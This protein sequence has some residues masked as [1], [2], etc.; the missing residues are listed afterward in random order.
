MATSTS[1]ASITLAA[2]AT[3]YALSVSGDQAVYGNALSNSLS[4]N[5]FDNF[6]SGN[7]GNDTLLGGLGNDTLLGGDGADRLDGGIG[8][9]SMAGGDGN[10][11]YYVDDVNDI[12][13]ELAGQGMDTVW[14][15]VSYT[16][17]A[18]VEALGLTGTANLTGTGNELANSISGNAGDNLIDGGAGN[19]TLLGGAGNDTLLGGEGNDLLNGGVGADV[20]MGGE[21]SD[22]L[23]GGL[24]ADTMQGGAGNDV[25]VVDNIGDVVIEDVNGGTDTVWAS[26]DYT[27]GDNVESLGLT[28]TANLT[29]IGNALANSISGNTG[30][31]LLDGGAGNDI[32]LGGAGDD[33]L[34]GGDG[35]DRLD[36]GLGAD[37]LVG[38]AGNDLY[39]IDDLGDV[40]VEDANGG[41]DSVSAS[42]D[43]TLGDTL[44]ALTLTGTADLTGTG[45][46]L[47]N[48]I[49]GNSGNN[50]LDGGA[51]ND[52]LVGGLGQ[53]TLIGGLG[54]DTFVVDNI[55][56]VVVEEAGQGIDTVQSSI[57]YTL[58]DTLENLSLIG[59][60]NLTGTGNA[61][62]NTL[63]GNAGNNVLDGGAGNDVLIGG[64][65][66][67]TLIG[68]AGN[69]GYQVDDIGDVVV[70]N[71][72]EGVDAVTIIATL[73]YTLGDNVENARVNSSGSMLTGNAMANQ[74]VSL[75]VSS[76]IYGMDGNDTISGGASS[77]LYGDNGDDSLT[78]TGTGS[79]AYGG[80]GNDTLDAR[81]TTGNWLVGG[82]GDDVYVVD[83]T[84]QY[85]LE[86]ANEGVDTVKSSVTFSLVAGAR[87][88]G[89]SVSDSLEN[90]TL[91]GTN[92]IDGTGNALG[93]VL[94]GN[95]AANLLLGNAGNDTLIGGGGND[96]LNGGT[97]NDTLRATA[98]GATG[99]ALAGAVTLIGGAGNDV[100]AMSKGYVGN[101]ASGANTLTIQDFVHGEDK[102][103][104]TLAKTMTQ[105]GAL[106][107]LTVGTSDTLDSLLARATTGGGPTAPKVSSF[108]FAGNTYLVLDQNAINGFAATDLAIKVTGTPALSFSD[109]AFAVV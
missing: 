78:L 107:Q 90:L 71:P 32:L 80:T 5:A 66:A 53:D 22:R 41:I 88:G 8:A 55:G 74:I 64:L 27:L 35:N 36:G 52:M 7:A 73:N 37:V 20:L 86:R 45:N 1:T 46:A 68:G 106:Q 61:L 56:D 102:I 9:D 2:T 54:N 47:A 76:I 3:T 72:D 65:G 28:G 10:D 39:V 48:S 79:F 83:S 4:G 12:V 50:R 57:S 21:G 70:E 82:A 77:S 62:A 14:A 13:T 75:G 69:D 87:T 59:S 44:E 23:E 63:I 16:L 51:G 103:S 105:P 97:G 25:Y 58:A 91:T 93:N 89:G 85:I 29:G 11:I 99:A 26:M 101:H 15:S 38:G 84:N 33:T 96:T 95:A 19:D 100:F 34:L 94:T 18:N 42:I 81:T 31:N 17:G 40:I 109:L 104:L 24:D 30:N 67:D 98:D 49:T 6:L 92:A 43:Y 108:V 60:A